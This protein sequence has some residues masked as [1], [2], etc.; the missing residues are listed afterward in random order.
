MPCISQSEIERALDAWAQYL[1]QRAA[2]ADAP[3][4]VV[5]IVSHGD[6]LAQRL[7]QRLQVA[8]CD[9]L[10]GA[11]DITLYRDDLDMRG[12]RPALRSSHLPFS[13][14]GLHLVLVDDVLST[15][16]TARAALEVLWEYGRPA[17]VELQ[18]LADR[19]GRQLPIH[20]DY[21]AFNLSAEPAD[22]VQV[23]LQEIDGV[24]DIT[25]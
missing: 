24:E 5:G 9:A 11:I 1:L 6:I 19:G 15:G 18:C 12:N 4:A 10:Y 2:V 14:D 25:Y 23:R 7:V 17:R 16:R 13:T 8:G 20:P 3:L 21:V 22:K